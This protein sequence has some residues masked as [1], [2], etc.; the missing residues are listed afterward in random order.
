[1]IPAAGK[2]TPRDADAIQDLLDNTDWSTISSK[3]AM[4]K[5]WS[6]DSSFPPKIDSKPETTKIFESLQAAKFDP[7]FW[8]NLSIQD[9][10]RLDYKQFTVQ[11]DP[12]TNVAALGASSVLI[13]LD[14]F[15][16]KEDLYDGIFK[17]MAEDAS[18]DFLAIL[19]FFIDTQTGASRRQLV[20][21][22]TKA[23]AEALVDKISNYLLNDEDCKAMLDL[24]PVDGGFS[25]CSGNENVVVK[26]FEQGNAKASR[27]QVAPLLIK[28]FEKQ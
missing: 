6:G 1:M 7:V 25:T 26:S 15:S 23:Q 13:S 20:L 27:K 4:E 21:C 12:E 16:S 10:L 9:A 19:F 3:K 22:G 5:W 11:K 28:F 8:K 24:K 2:G 17:Y 18:V 14:D